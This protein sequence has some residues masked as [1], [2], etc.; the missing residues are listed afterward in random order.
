MWQ[1][2]VT[3]CK[4][5]YV[6]R[7]QITMITSGNGKARSAEKL[8]QE[9][10]VRGSHAKQWSGDADG[11]ADGCLVHAAHITGSAV[12]ACVFAL[13]KMFTFN[14]LHVS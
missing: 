7:L 13:F 3:L 11:D 4:G 1:P 12:S 2:Q 9:K 10:S 8:E 14:V 5:Y 6:L